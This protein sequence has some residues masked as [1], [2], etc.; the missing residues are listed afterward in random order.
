MIIG[1]VMIIGDEKRSSAISLSYVIPSARV[2]ATQLV[3]RVD[4]LFVCRDFSEVEGAIRGQHWIMCLG[5][6]DGLATSLHVANPGIQTTSRPVSN[7][8]A[9]ES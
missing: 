6:A 4:N 7:D 2:H 1:N 5:A 3:K 9:T 8:Q